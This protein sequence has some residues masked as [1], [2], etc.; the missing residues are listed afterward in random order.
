MPFVASAKPPCEWQHHPGNRGCFWG[1]EEGQEGSAPTLCRQRSGPRAGVERKKSKTVNSVNGGYVGALWLFSDF[2]LHVLKVFKTFTLVLV[3]G[4]ATYPRI[5][6]HLE[7]ISKCLVDLWVD[8][9]LHP[10]VQPSPPPLAPVAL[11]RVTVVPWLLL[12]ENRSPR[13]PWGWH[14]V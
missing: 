13:S 2:F 6:P 9:P 14:W 11:S 1:W 7:K 8:P 4:P 12:M 10:L 5:W 3:P